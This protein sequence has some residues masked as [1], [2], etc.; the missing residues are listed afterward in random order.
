M[1]IQIELS[2]DQWHRITGVKLDKLSDKYPDL[3]ED[4]TAKEDAD[5]SA[6]L[7]ELEKEKTDEYGNRQ[8]QRSRKALEGRLK[9]LGIEEFTKAEEG[10][11]LLIEQQEADAGKDPAAKLN[12]EEVK[13]HP[14][15]KAAIAEETTSLRKKLED[16]KTEYEKYK[17]EVV[18]REKHSAFESKILAELDDMKAGYG[19]NGKATAI[20]RFFA[21]FPGYNVNEKG[22]VV[23]EQGEEILKDH[24]P[25]QVSDWLKDEWDYGFDQAPAHP[26][27]PPANGG[28]NGKTAPKY[29]ITSKAQFE[30]LLSKAA[31][32]DKA[33]LWASYNAVA[34]KIK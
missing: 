19:K 1:K 25:V 3:F 4:G 24:L 13:S 28:G 6:A 16:T 7:L 23:N 22:H 34:D 27:P 15:F 8:W 14:A 10:L 18:N 2:A 30:E 11:D 33:D 20:K 9:K 26:S 32:K 31:Q 17:A 21:V 29:N 12:A 5:F